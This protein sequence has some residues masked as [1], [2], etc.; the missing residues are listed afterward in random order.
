MLYVGYSYLYSRSSGFPPGWFLENMKDYLE[1]FLPAY[2]SRYAGMAPSQCLAIEGAQHLAEC[3]AMLVALLNRR[4]Y[5]FG[6]CRYLDSIR[7]FMK[8]PQRF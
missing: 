2:V 5:R 8:V 6:D 1:S 3:S 4:Y 7:T